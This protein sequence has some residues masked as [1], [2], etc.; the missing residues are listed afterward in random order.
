MRAV[1]LNEDK[2]LFLHGGGGDS[3]RSFR[4]ALRKEGE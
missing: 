3:I 4:L 2:H 1:F